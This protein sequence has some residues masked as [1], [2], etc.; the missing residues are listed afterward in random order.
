M[1]AMSA[2]TVRQ[3]ELLPSNPLGQRLCEIFSYH[4]H[5]LTAENAIAPEWKTNTKYPIRPRVLWQ[6]WNDPNILI[7]VRFGST[8]SYAVID[9]DCESLW[10]PANNPDGL[11][12]L[13]AALE[14]I[15]IVRSVLVRSSHSGGLHLY[16]PLPYAVPTFG[17]A[18]A[19][20]QC[21]EAQ[22]VT[23]SPGQVE[24]FP[25]V[26]AYAIPGTYIEYNGHRLPLQPDSGACLLDADGN[27]HG[28]D[29]VQF[30]RQ[31]DIA[32]DGQ[33]LELLNEAICVARRNGSR[34]KRHRIAPVEEWRS[35]LQAEINEGW[36]G[37]GQTNHLLK[38]IACYGVVFEGLTG[39]PLAEFVQTTAINAPGYEEFCQHQHE[40]TKRSI[41]WARAAEKYWWALGTD[42]KRSGTVFEGDSGESNVIPINKNQLKAEDA[43]RRIRGAMVRLEQERRLPAEV[44]GRVQALVKEAHT[45]PQTLYRYPNLWHPGYINPV[46]DRCVRPDRKGDTDDCDGETRKQSE[47]LKTLQDGKLH[48]RE[49][50]MKGKDILDRGYGTGVP[51]ER[52]ASSNVLAF[53]LFDREENLLNGTPLE[54]PHEKILSADEE[55]QKET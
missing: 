28:S 37:Q 11:A 45:S 36:T 49:G 40:I 4:W 32:A 8:T 39:E 26:K 52:I 24:T 50:K 19:L 31:W 46:E 48:T 7:G 44:T 22:G 6:R 3:S 9:I 38:T 23:I 27:S 55:I 18:Q 10:H 42:P 51:V 12:L 35:D 29:L 54:K 13:L 5:T 16:L 14:T 33:D 53:R 1:S 25:N 15:G 2:A 30:F 17:L 21:L 41:V 20:K 47:S 34:R 43:Q